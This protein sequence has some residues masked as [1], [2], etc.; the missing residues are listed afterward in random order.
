MPM[1]SP[2][3]IRAFLAINAGSVLFN[4]TGG[5]M[6]GAC[7]GGGNEG[8]GNGGAGSGGGGVSL[9]AM[10]SLPTSPS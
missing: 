7:S 2:K 1:E 10:F 3:Q 9:T 5:V 4:G 6:C 8:T